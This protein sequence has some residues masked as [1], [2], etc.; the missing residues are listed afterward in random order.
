MKERVIMIVFIL[1][2]GAVLTTALVAF[3]SYTAPRI[4]SNE[5]KK[6]QVNLMKI[7]GIPY[8]GKDDNSIR[9]A[10]AEN[11]TVVTR[12]ATTLYRSRAGDVAF[13]IRGPGA[14]GPLAGA[15][16]IGADLQ[17]LKG[18]VILSNS[19]TPGLGTRVFEA[20]YLKKYAGKKLVPALKVRAAGG[21]SAENEV[22]GITGATLTGVA[23]QNLINKE[24]VRI[25]PIITESE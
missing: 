11:V 9:Q 24:Y 5:D 21:A 23:F 4:K 13:E 16:A 8:D 20:E 14:L 22:D 1:I 18:V 3:D 17:S 6:L 25:K 10:F 12:H 7:L 15:M 19:E 2:L